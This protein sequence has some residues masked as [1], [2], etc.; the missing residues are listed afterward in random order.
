MSE[1]KKGDIVFANVIARKNNITK[2]QAT[3]FLEDLVGKEVM[4][5]Y[6]QKC[7][8]CGSFEDFDEMTSDFETCDLCD[9]KLIWEPIYVK[10]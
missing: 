10:I 2:H 9:G 8:E 7:C 6:R 3:V 5:R 4:K 1:Y